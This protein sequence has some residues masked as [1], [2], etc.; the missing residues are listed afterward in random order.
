MSWQLECPACLRR[1]PWSAPV[2]RCAC[3]AR[4]ESTGGPWFDPAAIEPNLPSLQRYRHALPELEPVTLGEGWTALVRE[5]LDGVPVWLK[6]DYLMPTGSFKDRGA[7]LLVSRLRAAGVTEVVEDSS[8]N[9][10]SALAAYAARAGLACRIYVPES[11]PAGKLQLMAACGA[12]VVRV[13]GPRSAAAAAVWSAAETTHYASHVWDPAYLVGT[14]TAAFEIAEQLGWECPDWVVTPTGNGTL[15]LGLAQGFARLR[16]AG[17][18]ERVPRLVAAMAAERPTMADG[19]AVTNPRLGPQIRAAVQATD[20]DS[21]AVT[22]VELMA[23]LALLKHNGWYL[24]PTA[25]AGPAAWSKLL[26]S[27]RAKPGENA[28][29]MLTGSGLKTTVS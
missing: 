14:Q 21:V 8:G 22:E 20:G 29:V 17:V 9:A 1:W 25:A 12:A 23:S 11:T 28:V 15:L 4:L 6:P 27:G 24:E 18:L 10:G 7:S 5:T 2:W 13:P 26:A 19:I 3:G 16:Q